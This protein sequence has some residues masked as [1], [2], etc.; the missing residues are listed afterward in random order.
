MSIELLVESQ[1]PGPGK[2]AGCWGCP[3]L[4][5]CIAINHCGDGVGAAVGV[6]LPQGP[7]DVG[8]PGKGCG[9]ATI[10][11]SLNGSSFAS[12]QSRLCMEAAATVDSA[13]G[14]RGVVQA[15]CD[16]ANSQ[17]QWSF[18]EGSMQ[19]RL[20]GAGGGAGQCL[21]IPDM[22]EHN[23]MPDRHLGVYGLP[24]GV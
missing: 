16:R 12:K 24:A 23:G 21:Q 1:G 18:V 11:F 3:Y 9:A 14:R 2:P 4:D 10:E 19:L 7:A 15:E 5:E 22:P 13:T 20:A 8:T 6:R 17:Q